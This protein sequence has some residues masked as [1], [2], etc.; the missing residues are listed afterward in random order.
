MNSRNCSRM[1]MKRSRGPVRNDGTM[2]IGANYEVLRGFSG[3]VDA[4]EAVANPPLPWPWMAARRPGAPAPAAKRRGAPA[5]IVSGGRPDAG[6]A[7]AHAPRAARPVTLLPA[8]EP[9]SLRPPA[10][11][12]TPK[13]RPV[14]ASGSASGA[15]AQYVAPA[16]RLPQ[17]LL[18]FI[19]FGLRFVGMGAFQPDESSGKEGPYRVGIL[20]GIVESQNKRKDWRRGA[21]TE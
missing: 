8:A 12:P 17:V 19:T 5:S 3:R 11:P 16:I 14:Q 1:A 21:P 13:A 20:Q 7:Q 6:D 4:P 15:T 18:R 2:A 10:R 9:R